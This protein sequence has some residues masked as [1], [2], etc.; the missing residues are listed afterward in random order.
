MRATREVIEKVGP[1]MRKDSLLMDLT[2]LKKEPV[3]AM[4]ESSVSEVIGCHPL[5]GPK[6]DSPAGETIVLCPA[7]S[8]R[9][10]SW[11]TDMLKKGGI[12]VVE[13]TPERHDRMMALVQ[14]LSHFNTIVMGLVLSEAGVAGEELMK[15]AT[16]AFRG[17]M[18]IMARLFC[19]NP[20][21]YADIL[22][23]N[24]ESEGLIDAYE[25]T[26]GMLKNMMRGRDAAG[27]TGAI[28]RHAPLF[29]G[30]FK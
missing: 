10:I 28:E 26:V 1:H 9:W 27:V 24:P 22:T 20:A 12:T 25:R 6:V 23:M 30:I 14:G 17:K 4:L 16:P 2:S 5:F 3:K 15:F 19:R 7:R 21:L 11:L 18:E 8:I 29:R 13:T